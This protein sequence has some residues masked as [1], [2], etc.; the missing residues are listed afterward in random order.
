MCESEGNERFVHE[1]AFFHNSSDET[2]QILEMM[3]LQDKP[4]YPNALSSIRD[5]LTP[6]EPQ[7]FIRLKVPVSP[8]MRDGRDWEILVFK[9]ST[10][11]RY[12]DEEIIAK[13]IFDKLYVFTY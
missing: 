9:Q 12:T 10:I 2:I 3:T 4:V 5:R 6:I 7:E 11:D 13:N 8:G 1:D